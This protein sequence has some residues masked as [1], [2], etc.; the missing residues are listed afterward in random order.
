MYVASVI[1]STNEIKLDN[2]LL[3]KAEMVII[4]SAKLTGGYNSLSIWAKIAITLKKNFPLRVDVSIESVKLLKWIFFEFKTLTSSIKL[5]TLIPSRS[6]FHTIKVSFSLN[7]SRAFDRP[8]L[9]S[10][11]PLNSSS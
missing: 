1:P 3:K 2:E 8:C 7:I 5:F 6:S 10:F 9:L 4:E 11:V